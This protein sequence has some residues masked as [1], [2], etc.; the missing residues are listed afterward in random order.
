MKG[1]ANKTIVS[2]YGVPDEKTSLIDELLYGMEATV[3]EE[4][5]ATASCPIGWIKIETEYNYIGYALCQNFILEGNK[6]SSLYFDWKKA[7]KKRI[8]QAYVDLLSEPRVQGVI[9]EQVTRGG[10]VAFI[11][12]VEEHRGWIEV[13]LVDGRTGYTKKK[14]LDNIYRKPEGSEEEI[15]LRVIETAKMYLGTQYRWGGK[16]P[17]G[18]DCSGLTSICYLLNGIRTYRDADIVEGFSVRKILF[19][20]RKQGDL[21]YFKGHIAMLLDK[22]R[23]IHSTGYSGSDGVVINSLCPDD[24]D[25]REDLA[26]G[27]LATGSV[28]PL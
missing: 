23:Y 9:L 6:D 5:A 3:L 27:V 14:F 13:K 11:G 22:N 16:S 18:I 19:E 15:R 7:P 21:L 24:V 20:D 12:E 8:M 28:F 1:I 25:Y 4:E 2:I 17:L 26:N 10:I